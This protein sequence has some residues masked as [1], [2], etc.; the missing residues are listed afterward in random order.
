M[1][2]AALTVEFTEDPGVF[3]ALAGAH[4]T[5]DP[6]LTTVVSTVTHRAL[7]N[8]AAG[9][10]RPDHP[11]WWVVVREGSEVV[12][13]AMRTAPFAPYPLFVLPMAEQAARAIAQALR[14][15]GEH[16]G[17]VNGAGPAAEA[18]AGESARLQGGAAHV[19][20]RTRL[21][22]LRTLVPPAPVPGWLRA[23]GADDLA[24]VADWFNAFEADAAAQAGRPAPGGAGLRFEVDDLEERIAERRVWLWEDE[25]G[26][27]AHLTGHT[28]PAFGVSR[29]GPVYTPPGR[30]GRGFAS[31]AV[32]EVAS[33]FV[34]NRVRVCLFTDQA[35]PTSNRI[36]QA[37][38]FEP[39]VDMVNLVVT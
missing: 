31:A 27:V 11:R 14:D 36:Y 26:E 33:R 12:G 13:L 24:L 8:D 20:E 21:F 23:A 37:L 2:D 32:A 9:L 15:R 6:L 35:N 28:L 30:R 17:G 34:D 16:V 38:G 5:Q 3:L 10:P 29:I 22:E 39:V 7:A 1:I 4:L 18:L 19:E 25:R